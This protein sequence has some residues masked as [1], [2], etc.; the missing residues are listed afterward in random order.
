MYPEAQLLFTDTDS[1]YYDIARLN[2]EKELYAHKELFH[3]SD[4]QEKS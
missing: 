3:Y 4:Y 2:L 1:F